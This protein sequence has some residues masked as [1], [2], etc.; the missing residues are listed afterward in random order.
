[1]SWVARHA[2]ENGCSRM[3][4]PVQASNVRGISFY[5]SIGGEPVVERLSYRLSESSMSQ[6]ASE[7][8]S[9]SHGG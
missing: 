6:L 2:L 9:A 3:D 5:E 8:T 1:M 7:S 4:W